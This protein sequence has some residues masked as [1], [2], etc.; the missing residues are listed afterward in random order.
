LSRSPPRHPYPRPFPAPIQPL[1]PLPWLLAC[2]KC[3]E[4]LHPG[5]SIA[6][7]HPPTVPTEPSTPDPEPSPPLAIR[8]T[9]PLRNS[10]LPTAHRQPTTNLHQTKPTER[11]PKPLQLSPIPLFWLSPACFFNQTKPN[12]SPTSLPPILPSPHPPIP[13]CNPRNAPLALPAT[14]PHRKTT[15]GHHCQRQAAWLRNRRDTVR[16]RECVQQLL[17][18]STDGRRSASV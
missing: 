6:L 8:A 14:L 18:G 17:V 16:G 12:S 5:D 15:C 2:Y 11:S 13:P 1:F 9:L 7:A 10:P 3:Y 4:L